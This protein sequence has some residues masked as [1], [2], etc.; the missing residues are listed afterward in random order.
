M[1]KMAI[2]H[3]CNVADQQQLLSSPQQIIA[4]ILFYKDD[5]QI[6]VSI[7]GRDAWFNRNNVG[8][9]LRL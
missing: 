7:L 2:D 4:P 5:E 1:V 6:C 9:L 3:E 8:D